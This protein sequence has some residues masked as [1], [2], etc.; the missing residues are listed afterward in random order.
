MRDTYGPTMRHLFFAVVAQQREN[1]F[2]EHPRG[3]KL[4]F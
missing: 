2:H 1:P 3:G 4:D